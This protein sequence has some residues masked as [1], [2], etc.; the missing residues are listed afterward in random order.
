MFKLKLISSQKGGDRMSFIELYDRID[1]RIKELMDDGKD[2]KE[3]KALA[4]EEYFE[5]IFE[6]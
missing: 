1:A 4:W 5:E 6:D 3:A 2:E